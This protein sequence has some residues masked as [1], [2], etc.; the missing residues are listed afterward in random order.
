VLPKRLVDLTYNADE[1][2]L[3]VTIDGTNVG[4]GY[5]TSEEVAI[6]LLRANEKRE[7]YVG[8]N[9]FGASVV[10][11]KQTYDSYSII[12]GL[13][14]LPSFD[15]DIDRSRAATLKDRLRI[16]AVV[17][18]GPESVLETGWQHLGDATGFRHVKATFDDPE[19][20]SI[21]D[22]SLRGQLLELWLFDQVSGQ[23]IRRVGADGSTQD[24]DERNE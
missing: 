1:G 17:G 7:K 3:S 4:I 10:V 12:T 23:V 9:A 11:S 22:Y 20:A 13:R 6:E 24:S 16:L 19:E 14:S 15:V 8:S 21:F 5:D 18:L 2:R